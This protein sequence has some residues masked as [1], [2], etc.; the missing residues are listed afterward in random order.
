MHELAVHTIVRTAN[1]TNKHRKSTQKNYHTISV[2]DIQRSKGLANSL[3]ITTFNYVN[4][5]HV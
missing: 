4:S 1:L 2:P 5:L 3:K